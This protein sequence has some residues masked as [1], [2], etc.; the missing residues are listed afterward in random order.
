MLKQWKERDASMAYNETLEAA[1]F[2]CNMKDA[3]AVL[4]KH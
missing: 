2:E 4:N 3:A 1:L